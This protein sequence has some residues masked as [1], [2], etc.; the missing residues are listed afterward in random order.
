MAERTVRLGLIGCGGISR[1]HVGSL[2]GVEG[3]EIVGL[4]DVNP[5]NVERLRDLYPELAGAATY[6]DHRALL[7]GDLD[8]AIVMTPHALHYEQ[9]RAALEAGKHVLCEKPFVTQ[10]EQARELIA[11]ARARERVLMVAYQYARLWPYRYAHQQVADGKLGEILFYS[12]QITQNWTVGGGWRASALGEGGF[13]V[14]TGSHF[15]DLMLYLTGMAPEIVCAFADRA[16][17]EV[18]IV[19]GAT[20]RFNGGRVAT[21]A[22][23]G[24]GPTL[25][26]ITIIGTGGTIEITDR[27]TIRHIG[28]DNYAGW[29]GTERRNLVPPPDE[30]P[31]TTT[32]DE[33]FVAAI[34]RGDHTA[35]DAVRGL[36]VAQLTRAIYASAAQGGAPV[37]LPAFG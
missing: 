27:D 18:D 7:A 11:L 25:W 8:G 34:R 21:L 23:A 6:D 31:C 2:R 1:L 32:P 30:R 15:V 17:Q 19:T 3:V 9:V 28:A 4:A 10:P 24:R 14:D 16:G 35:S 13:L 37:A 12:S 22:A 5:A 36:L 33:E 20:I 29:I 26:N